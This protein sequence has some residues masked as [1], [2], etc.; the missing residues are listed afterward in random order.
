MI[1]QHATAAEFSAKSHVLVTAKAGNSKQNESPF[2]KHR[3]KQRTAGRRNA[4][5][6]RRYDHTGWRRAGLNSIAEE[7]EE[8]DDN[9]NDNEQTVIDDKTLIQDSVSTASTARPPKLPMTQWQRRGSMSNT[10]QS[11]TYCHYTTLEEAK[12]QPRQSQPGKHFPVD[13]RWESPKSTIRLEDLL[14]GIGSQFDDLAFS[15]RQLSY[16]HAATTPCEGATNDDK[17]YDSRDEYDNDCTYEHGETTLLL[18]KGEDSSHLPILYGELP[19][20]ATATSRLKLG[21]YLLRLSRALTRTMRRFLKSVWEVVGLKACG[22]LCA[23]SSYQRRQR[24]RN[25][26]GREKQQGERG[27][28]Y[29]T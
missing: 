15:P 2:P 16:I 1:L 20:A 21:P 13:L 8:E 17:C 18:A 25:R 19:P 24:K 26:H 27:L 12:G 22:G 29:L 11:T 3:R 10:K 28:I 14:F 5:R 4:P 7:E 23:R 6:G 9:D